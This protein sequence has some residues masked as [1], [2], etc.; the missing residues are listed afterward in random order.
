MEP[1]KTPALTGYSCE[2]FPSRTT[3]NC[4]LLRKEEIRPN[5]W[6]GE[7]LSLWSRPACKALSKVGPGYSKHYSAWVASGLLKALAILSDATVRGSAVDQGELTLY[8]KSQK[9]PHFSRWSTILLFTSFSKTLLTTGRWLTG[10]LFLAV[11]LEMR[12][13][14]SLENKNLWGTYRQQHWQPWR[15]KI[16]PSLKIS[17]HG[18]SNYHEDRPTQHKSSHKLYHERGHS[19]LSLMK[20]QWK[21]RQHQNFTM[22]GQHL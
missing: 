12:P 3:Q 6:P 4:L 15:W 8:R 5:T 11:G 19:V 21:L 18:T 17:Y 20:S 16:T 9:R 7:D 2:E 14:N 10:Q 1:W 22:E 13:S